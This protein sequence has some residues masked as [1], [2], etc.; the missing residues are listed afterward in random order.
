MPAEAHW[1]TGGF[2][3]QAVDHHVGT[4]DYTTISILVNDARLEF[5]GSGIAERSH[6]SIRYRMSIAG[7]PSDADVLTAS[8]QALTNG[9]FSITTGSF[10]NNDNIRVK[11]AFYSGSNGTGAFQMFS[12]NHVKS[13]ILGSNR[14]QIWRR[15]RTLHAYDGS[16]YRLFYEVNYGRTFTNFE[17]FDDTAF[18]NGSG[19]VKIEMVFD[20]A[21]QAAGISV[22]TEYSI[23]FGISWVPFVGSESAPSTNVF[24]ST[25]DMSWVFG[26]S[27]L[28]DTWFRMSATVSSVNINGSPKQQ[29]GGPYSC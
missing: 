23:D 7:M 25:Y 20:G 18:C 19:P 1:R 9:N 21:W 10:V 15:I 22:V 8:P 11:A 2:W 28:S 4:N 5:S 24:Q 13:G 16:A 12:S 26:F 29:N 27:T 17:I 3:R 6:L 14:T